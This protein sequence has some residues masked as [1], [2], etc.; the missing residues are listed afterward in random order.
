MQIFNDRVK[1][2][3]KKKKSKNE[4]KLIKSIDGEQQIE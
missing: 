3:K 4:K 1:R 2:K